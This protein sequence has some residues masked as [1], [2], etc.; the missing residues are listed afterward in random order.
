MPE[1][2]YVFDLQLDFI[3]FLIKKYKI[4]LNNLHLL[5]NIN[6]IKSIQKNKKS[7]IIM[8]EL[9][10]HFKDPIK[11]F[12]ESIK[13][14]KPAYLFMADCFSQMG[15]GHFLKYLFNNEEISGPAMK[16]K[17]TA[18]L[19]NLNYKKVCSGWNAKP[20]LWKLEN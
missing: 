3:S 9:I 10:E 18:F 16:R 6:K 1:D 19:K 12:E 5:N 7:C 14:L 2:V 4:S 20:V 11:Y 17:F 13:P 15:M 8:F